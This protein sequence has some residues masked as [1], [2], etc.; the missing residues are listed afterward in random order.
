MASLFLPAASFATTGPNFDAVTWLQ[1]GCDSP[2]LIVPASPASASFVG[3]Q[4][5]PPA[6]YAYDADYLYFRYRMDN[7]PSH[8]GGFDQYV[9]TALMQVP[10]GNRFQYQYQLSLNGKNA[11]GDSIEIWG[12]TV[13][14]DIRF[15]HFQDDA[16]VKLYSVPVGSL[17]RTV[18]A[19]TS[20]N[21]NPDRFLDFAFPVSTL[22]AKGVIASA[23]DLSQSFFFPATSTN[24]NNYSKSYLNC[25]FQPYTSLAV[26][27]SVAPA[28]AP[29]N[30]VT[31]VTYTID[32]QN[33]GQAVGLVVEDVQLPAFLGNIAVNATTDDPGATVT[34]LQ[35]NPL[36]VESPTL[37]AGAHIT[38]KITADAAPGCGDAD[39]VNTATAYATNALDRV[40]S[41]T[42]DVQNTNGPE[43]CD[44][45]DNDC[46][47]Q[48]DEGADQLCDDGNACNGVETCGGAAGCQPG[49]PLSCDDGNA[50]NGVETCDPASGCKAGT[51]LTCDDGNACNGTE[52]CDPASGC[53]AGTPLTCDDGNACNSIETRGPASGCHAGTPLTCDAGNACNGVETCDPASGCH[54]GTPLSCDDH[55]ACNGV[56][57]CDPASGC[58]AGTPLSCDD[59]NACNGL[60]TC[61]PASGCHA[62]TP[63]TCGHGNACTLETGCTPCAS[64]ADCDDGDQCT[65]DTCDSSVCGSFLVEGCKRCTTAA[66][67]DDGNVCNGV[68]TC[69]PATGCH[70]GTPLSCDDGNACNGVEICDPATGCHAGTPLACDDGNVCNGD[71]SCAPK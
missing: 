43:L 42:L 6:F 69:D 10:S 2:D 26:Q 25:P 15:P 33:T 1:L 46:D 12:N 55:N 37:A 17:A 34:V 30:A 38:V 58:H 16:E 14:S 23:A 28:V 20:F 51:P 66:D 63:L 60:E 61:D 36:K 57:T 49:T 70:A 67:C 45:K 8:G 59:H 68:E 18:S 29:V 41:A 32:V 52:T 47:G 22:I 21:G 31:P 4:A 13:A 50:C 3:D 35:T 39:F 71:A 48:I 65:T 40:A 53:K 19:G 56:E 54:A 62:G 5:N 24:P 64:K 11:S 7:D 27:K 44:G 9:W